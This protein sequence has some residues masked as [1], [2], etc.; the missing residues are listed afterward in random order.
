M[1]SLSTPSIIKPP[2]T[3]ETALQKVKFAQD[4]W[5]SKD[6]DRIC[7][8]YTPD[9]EWRNRSEFLKGHSEIREFLQRKFSNELDYKLEKQLFAFLD[10]RISVH[11][12]YEYHNEEGQWFRAYGN[13]NWKFDRESG[14][15]KKRD[16]SINDVK[17]E[18]SERRFK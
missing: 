14:L 17:I 10:D 12:E 2:F 11:F 3:L 18:E 7:K 6:I 4:A 15:M 1:S 5:N 13:E 8:A 9:C 16:A